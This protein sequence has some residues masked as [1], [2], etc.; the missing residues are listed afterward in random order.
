MV[1]THLLIPIEKL[2]E[3]INNH[4]DEKRKA[5]SQGNYNKFDHEYHTSLALEQLFVWADKV[6]VE[7]NKII[8]E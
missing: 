6:K 7:G 3:V 5:F 2:R 1:E 8:T 4:E